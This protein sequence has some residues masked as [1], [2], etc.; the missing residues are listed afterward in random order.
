MTISSPGPSEQ[1]RDY[2]L[3]HAHCLLW[4][5]DFNPTHWEI[6]VV[7]E[8]AA[9]VWLP[10]S[11]TEGNSF[12]QDLFLA[13]SATHQREGCRFIDEA[14]AANQAGVTRE[15]CLILADGSPL[16]V[17]EEIHLEQT[18]PGGG[19]AAGAWLDITVRKQAESQLLHDACHDSLTQLPNRSYL[20]QL[21]E[22]SPQGAPRFLLFLD[23][24]NFKV[25]NDTMGHPTGDQVLIE[26]A[27]R[28]RQS[29]GAQGDVIRLGGDEFTVLLRLGAAQEE[30]LALSEKILEQIKR[31]LLLLSGNNELLHL[32][33]SIGIS[34]GSE[35]DTVG[36]LR[37]ADIAMY[38]AKGRGRGCSV[39]FDATMESRLRERF[40]LEKLLRV[41][42]DCGELTLA[43]QP[44]VQLSTGAIVGLESLA[45][46]EHPT[47]GFIPPD[48]F[49]PVAEEAG[50]ITALGRLLL[51]RAC[52]SAM[53]WR[54]IHPNLAMGVNVSVAQLQSGGY[55]E[56]VFEV[57][58][59]TGLPAES[60]V[61]EITESILALGS[62]AV[63]EQLWQLYEAGVALVLDD[64]GTGYSSFSALSEFPLHAIKID[65]AFVRRAIDGDSS[66]AQRNR[67]LIHA[68]ASAGRA[69]D[70]LVVAEGIETQEQAQLVQELGCHLGQGFLIQ[71]PMTEKAVPTCLQGARHGTAS[72]ARCS[73]QLRL[74]A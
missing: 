46:W 38:A 70:L 20:A 24:D 43:Y 48:R 14:I 72:E 34:T 12:A 64:F 21:L 13:R 6:T 15:F 26:V 54:S 44:L 17:Q 1:Q 69:L 66:R 63:T 45:R 3:R 39:V 37:N 7:N 62:K 73:Q 2:V 42:L 18:S 71:D 58:A 23:L 33:A 68:I 50:L 22:E 52:E 31:P 60:L 29:V 36:L 65:R 5:A 53:R 27:N 40:D 10:I 67:A 4:Y 51:R 41:A 11:R 61:L 49:I 56:S 30:A 25:I 57:L 28:L 55:V 35:E 16:W 74:V 47:L 8:E 32:S 19:R 9:R 59:Q